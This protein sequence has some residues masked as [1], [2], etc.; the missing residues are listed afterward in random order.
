MAD[1][2]LPS[3]LIL[4]YNSVLDGSA[5][6]E[7]FSEHGYSLVHVDLKDWF[8][9]Y[10]SNR[11]TD[12]D[13]DQSLEAIASTIRANPET[14]AVFIDGSLAYHTRLRESLKE[15]GLAPDEI[16]LLV[17]DPINMKDKDLS[18]SGCSFGLFMTDTRNA[19]DVILKG[20]PIAYI[21][22]GLGIKYG[23]RYNKDLYLE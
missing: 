1:D 2:D 17:A 3:K 22:S 9:A 4:I 23:I 19:I 7:V 14:E 13:N 20:N 16:P 10:L 8:R 12:E 5:R 11:I 15:K 21:E 18:V 6:T